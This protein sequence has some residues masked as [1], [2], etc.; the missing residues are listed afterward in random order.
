MRREREKGADG[1]A[2]K[3]NRG[4]R[5]RYLSTDEAISPYL[6]AKIGQARRETVQI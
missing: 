3:N 4:K 1:G 2:K 6:A 5:L